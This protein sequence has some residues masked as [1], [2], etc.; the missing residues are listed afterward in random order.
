LFEDTQLFNRLQI[1]IRSWIHDLK[2]NQ[3]RI[4]SFKMQ[5]LFFGIN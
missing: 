3:T 2:K 4:Y 5:K 1:S